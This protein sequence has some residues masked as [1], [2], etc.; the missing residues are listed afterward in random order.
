MRSLGSPTRKPVG[1]TTRHQNDGV[2]NHSDGAGTE[3]R[4]VPPC[5]KSPLKRNL[6]HSDATAST[7]RAWAA[8]EMPGRPKRCSALPKARHVPPLDRK[9]EQVRGCECA[10]EA[11]WIAGRG[12]KAW[13]PLAPPGPGLNALARPVHIALRHHGASGAG[14]RDRQ[15]TSGPRTLGALPD[16]RHPD[17]KKSRPRPLDVSPPPQCAHP[18]EA[19]T[20]CDRKL[21]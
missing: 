16:L 1:T 9:V 7:V 2:F 12:G 11:P 19:N 8:R 14:R 20:R 6:A 13:P 5:P 17:T 15:P 4:A 18:D 21:P 10:P 3:S